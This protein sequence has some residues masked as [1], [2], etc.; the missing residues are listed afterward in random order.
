MED[1]GVGCTATCEYRPE[2]ARLQAEVAWDWGQAA[3]PTEQ[4]EHVDVWS[5]PAVGRL[6]DANCDGAVDELDPPDVVFVSGRAI[7]V[8]TG[9][10]TCCHC[11]GASVSACLSGVLRVVDGRTGAEVWSLRRAGPMSIGFSGIS[12]ALGDLDGDGRMNVAA[13]TGEGSVVILEGD[14]TVLRT[15]DQPIPGAT[16]S[17]FGW[18]GGLAIADMEG[19]GFPEIAF[20]ATVFTTEAGA[21]TR[22]FV[23]TGGIGGDSVASAL[24]TF[25]DLDGA[26]DLHLE[27]LAGRTARVI[28]TMDSPWWW[29]GLYHLRSAHRSLI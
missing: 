26:A 15:S 12:V 28:A 7:D 10:G 27:L 19:D 20:G 23:G 4:P 21:L 9:Q 3:P 1:G 11:T 14:G 29:Y 18:G 16:V 8:A 25:A 24:S 17:T 2:V 22:R 13:V 6:Y 5:T